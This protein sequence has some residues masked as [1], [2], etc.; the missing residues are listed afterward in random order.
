MTH[1]DPTDERVEL[2]R[3]GYE[4]WNK[5]DRSWVLEH[6]SPNVEWITPPED[7]DPGTYRGYE[8]V[9]RFWSQ[10]RAAV[11]QL[12]FA[13]QEMFAVGDNVVVTALRSGRGE[14]SGLKVSDTVIQV[15]TFEDDTCVRVHEYYDRDT[16]L[17]EL[18]VQGLAEQ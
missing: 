10:W 6:M 9:E 12:N 1:G 8:G 4:A 3:R 11:G 14:H 7:P 17:R 18:G 15:F 2:V 16:A 13:P 5:G